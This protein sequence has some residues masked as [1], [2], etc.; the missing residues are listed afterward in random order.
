MENETLC[1]P[2][3]LVFVIEVCYFVSTSH[4]YVLCEELYWLTEL[5]VQLLYSDIHSKT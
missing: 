5:F 1:S 4:Q 2:L 3:L